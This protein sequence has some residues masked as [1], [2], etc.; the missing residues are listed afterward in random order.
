MSI[1][2]KV[3]GVRA[4][5]L[6][7]TPNCQRRE[8]AEIEDVLTHVASE[9]NALK[10]QWEG[11]RANFHVVITVER[12]PDADREREESLQGEMGSDG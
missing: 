10:K 6:V 1:S 3:P 4:K 9:L 7:I 8:G 2:S 5:H 12:L 11:R